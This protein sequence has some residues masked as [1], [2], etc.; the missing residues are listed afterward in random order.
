M[1][2]GAVAPAATCRGGILTRLSNF[3]NAALSIR[4]RPHHSDN[5]VRVE[6]DDIG[7]GDSHNPTSSQIHSPI[8]HA[9]LPSKPNGNHTGKL[10]V[11]PQI[12]PGLVRSLAV[13]L[14]T[15]PTK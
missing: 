13:R 5:K 4:L 3:L 6:T 8:I 10:R 9:P 15:R 14:L 11:Y 2:G 12:G 1:R 7:T